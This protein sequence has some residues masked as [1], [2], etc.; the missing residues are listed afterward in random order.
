MSNTTDQSTVE[1]EPFAGP[2][3]FAA[4]VA[5]MVAD[6]APRVFRGGAGVR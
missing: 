6:Q 3:E 4:L 1:P 2:A 5:E